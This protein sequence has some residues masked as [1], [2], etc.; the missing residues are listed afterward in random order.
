MM[1]RFRGEYAGILVAGTFEKT[2]ALSEEVIDTHIAQLPRPR[3]HFDRRNLCRLR[4]LI[5][6]INQSGG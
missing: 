3:F 4:Q 1:E 5:D 6:A 2:K